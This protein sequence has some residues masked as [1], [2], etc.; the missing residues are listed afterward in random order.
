[1]TDFVQP[2]LDW[3][4]PAEERKEAN[5][6]YRL[7][8]LLGAPSPKDIDLDDLPRSRSWRRRLWLNQGQ[9][10]ACTGFALAHCLGIGYGSWPLTDAEARMF[11]QWA[12]RFDQWA[13]EDYSGSSVQGACEGAKHHGVIRDYHWIETPQ[14][15]KAAI[16]RYGALDV[17]SWWKTGMWKADSN[18]Y[19]HATGA[20]EGGH[21]YAV[22]AVDLR[23]NRGR[24]DNSWGKNRWGIDGSA[25]IDLDELFDLIFNQRGETAL[26][27]KVRYN[28]G[29]ILPR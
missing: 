13:G 20:N 16:A 29:L 5:Q 7:Y 18:G 19:V 23:R 24:I 3:H 27:R 15:F 12:K 26:V 21:S 9:E 8:G 2:V 10:G 25:W 1:M 14:E 17:G 22:G 4:P 28:P 6:D 11:Y